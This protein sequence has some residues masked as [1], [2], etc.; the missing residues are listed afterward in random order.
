M[1]LSQTGFR[2]VN[3]AGFFAGPSGSVLMIISSPLTLVLGRALLAVM[4]VSAAPGQ[5]DETVPP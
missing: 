2:P 3:P 1:V 4:M 5:G